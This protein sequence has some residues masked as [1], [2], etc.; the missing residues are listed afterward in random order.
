MDFI[1][2]TNTDTYDTP[3]SSRQVTDSPMNKAMRNCC[4][5]EF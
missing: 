1:L 5:S 3:A 2:D 4:D